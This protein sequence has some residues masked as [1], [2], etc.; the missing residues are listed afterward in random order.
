MNRAIVHQAGVRDVEF[1]A[2]VKIVEFC[3]AYG[4]EIGDDHEPDRRW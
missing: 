2:R 3:N 1:G 4:C